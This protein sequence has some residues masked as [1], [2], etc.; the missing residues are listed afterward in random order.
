MCLLST[1]TGNLGSYLT[2]SVSTYI[3]RDGGITWEQVSNIN[4]VYKS[5]VGTCT[6]MY[7]ER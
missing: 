1:T 4:M 7:V 3:S 6:S 2:G 5:V